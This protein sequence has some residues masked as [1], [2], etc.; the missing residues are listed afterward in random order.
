MPLCWGWQTKE[1]LDFI[2]KACTLLNLITILVLKTI[3][4]ESCQTNT[5]GEEICEG[6]LDKDL[7]VMKN[8]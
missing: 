4:D 6:G 2:M 3:S 1:S 7:E 8:C 5:D